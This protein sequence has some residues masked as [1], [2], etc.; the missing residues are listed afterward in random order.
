MGVTFGFTMGCGPSSPAQAAASKAK[1]VKDVDWCLMFFSG[2]LAVCMHTLRENMLCTAGW[3]RYTWSVWHHEWGSGVNS[4]RFYPWKSSILSRA[5][6]RWLFRYII[7]LLADG[8]MV[9]FGKNSMY[10]GSIIMIKNEIS[11]NN[12]WAFSQRRSDERRSVGSQTWCHPPFCIPSYMYTGSYKFDANNFP[13][14]DSPQFAF[15]KAISL[16]L[17]YHG[18]RVCSQEPCGSWCPQ[19]RP[20]YACILYAHAI[21]NW[22]KWFAK[23][24]W[25]CD[26]IPE[27]LCGHCPSFDVEWQCRHWKSPY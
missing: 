27:G 4:C 10:E 16:S 25:V 21:L 19:G 1:D 22:P 2:I 8:A 18:T 17:R 26:W 24:D 5:E 12:G 11:N 9:G 7:S 15:I 13:R 14:Y 20:M 23:I 6:M 3:F